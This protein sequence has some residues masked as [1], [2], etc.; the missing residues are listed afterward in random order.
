MA[1]PTSRIT[2][3]NSP[4]HG[5]AESENPTVFDNAST[6]TRLTGLF[7]NSLWPSSFDSAQPSS[8]R[9]QRLPAPLF[10]LGR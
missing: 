1:L 7:S 3:P 5:E 2:K 4:T 10:Y 9:I 8:N 6:F